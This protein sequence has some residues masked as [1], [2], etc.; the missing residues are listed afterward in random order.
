MKTPILETERLILRPL[1]VEDAE[2]VYQNWSGD[3]EVAKF[4]RWSTHENVEVTREWLKEVEQNTNSD[5]VY[6]WGFVRKAD[7]KLIGSGGLYFK[8]EHGCFELGYNIM[9]DCWRQGYTSEAAAT[10]VAFAFKTLG[11]TR[12]HCC[13]AI[14]NPN[15]GKVMEKVGFHY[16]GDGHYDSFDGTRHFV[17][18][19]YELERTE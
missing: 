6:D 18:R 14:E 19:E 9:R 12:L 17:T 13:H 15:S 7:N 10:I 1:T 11:E 4:M 3:P 16:V 5:T 2:E 8:E